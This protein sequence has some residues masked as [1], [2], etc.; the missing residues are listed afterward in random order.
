MNFRDEFHEH[1]AEHLLGLYDCPDRLV[2][3]AYNPVL[4]SAGGFRVF[5]RNLFGKDAGLTSEHIADLAGAMVRRVHGFCRK[6]NIPLEDTATRERKGDSAASFIPRDPAF[7]GLFL[8]QKSMAP[9]PVWHVE[10]HREKGYIIKLYRPKKWHCVRHLFFHIM[11]CEWGHV[12]IRM[13]AHPPFG[14]MVILNGHEWVRRQAARRGVEVRMDGNCFIEGTDF[15]RVGALG[16]KLAATPMAIKALADRWIY[17][18]C[19]CFG[20][21]TAEQRETGFHYEYSVFQMEYS[22]NYVFNRGGALDQIY[23]SLVDRTRRALGLEELKTILGFKHRPQ[24]RPTMAIKR[25]CN[26][27]GVYDLTTLTVIWGGLKLKI[28][29]KSGRLLRAEV[30]VNNAKALRCARSLSNIP[31]I[32]DRLRTILKHFMDHVQAMNAA[33]IGPDELDRWSQPGGAGGHRLAGINLHNARIRIVLSLLPLLSTAPDGFSSA[34]LLE[35]VRKHGGRPGYSIAQAR[36]D[37]QKLRGKGLVGRPPR[38]RKYQVRAAC[39][40]QVSA[41]FALNGEII[42]PLLA[43]SARPIPASQG[44]QKNRA[45]AL[46]FQLLDTLAELRREA[47]IAA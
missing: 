45:D 8:V 33:F 29:D 18:A 17:S 43:A 21:S 5:W 41:Y 10:R 20:L 44:P 31:A 38:R 23:Q 4:Q 28:Y 36:Y 42:R 47:G 37:L 13:C 26:V 35:G 1:Y 6:R 2:F 9:A 15:N 16:E 39:V 27:Q 40:R 24:G 3:L 14:A 25:S 12:T 32:M 22:R 19:L 30:T 46:R 11:D 7:T 34:D